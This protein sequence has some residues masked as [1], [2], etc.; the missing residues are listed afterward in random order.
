M[1][2]QEPILNKQAPHS[3]EE[4][5]NT[6]LRQYFKVLSKP[7]VASFSTEMHKAEWSLVW[8]QFVGLIIVFAIFGLLIVLIS[9]IVLSITDNLD[10]IALASHFGLILLLALLVSIVLIA[11]D[12]LTYVTA[13]FFGGRGTLLNHTHSL[14]LFQVPLCTIALL[15]TLIPGAGTFLAVLFGLAALVYGV[16][17]QVFMVI[18][19]HRLDARNA[20]AT[21]FIPLAVGLLLTCSLIVVISASFGAVT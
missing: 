20:V 16:V 19:V 17:L 2:S 6:L 7:S 12:I 14:L 15:L 11:S 21:V 1:Q 10:F 9:T 4:V 8:I 3:L 18:A 5:I 13:R